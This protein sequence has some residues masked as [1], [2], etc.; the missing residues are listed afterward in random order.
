VLLI[1]EGAGGRER[2]ALDRQIGLPEANSRA[3]PGCRENFLYVVKGAPLRVPPRGTGP[4]R[5][6]CDSPGR[7]T[8]PI[9]TAQET[10]CTATK[11]KYS[12]SSEEFLA[13]CNGAHD[14]ENTLDGRPGD[15]ADAPPSG[16]DVA[17]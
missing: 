2:R 7:P 12:S 1:R 6:A 13:A 16:R 11:R 17:L 15:G 9:G 14:H 5:R 4:V 8:A 10:T 3:K